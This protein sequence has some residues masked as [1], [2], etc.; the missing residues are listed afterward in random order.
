MDKQ[1]DLSLRNSNTARIS[2]IG[3]LIIALI[4]VLGTIWVVRSAQSDNEKAVRAVSVLY[5]DELAGRREQVVENNLQNKIRDLRVA[6]DLMSDEDLSDPEHLRAYQA[7]MKKLYRLEKF[8][9]VDT[10]GVR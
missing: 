7:R 9:F 5:L 1:K 2:I 4:I 10:D 3:S 8:A 6:V